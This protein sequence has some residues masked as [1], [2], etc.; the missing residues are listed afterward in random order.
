MTAPAT[1][2]PPPGLRVLV[3]AG[4]AGIGKSIAEGFAAVGARVHISD[5]DADAVSATC[6]DR[7]TGTVADAANEDA[8]RDLFGEARETLGGLDVLVANAG[9]EGPT[10]PISDISAGDWD[11]TLDINLR[12]AYLAA[13]FASEDL[14]ASRG[15]FIGIASV[16][17]RLPFA[18]RT[19]YAASKWGVVGLAKSLA[20]ELGPQGVRANAILPGIVEGPRID[21]VIN[22]RAERLGLSYEEMRE[23][24]L[25]KVALRRMVSPD[26]IAAMCLF[27]NTPGGSNI[28]GQA[29]SVCAGVETL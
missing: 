7:I 17:G 19:P 9:I 20:S 16:A 26:D 1:L 12:G 29:L 4:A 22:A 21:R 15:S 6:S 25:E 23:R 18:Y 28:T 27:L 24:N 10:G 2:T 8:T 14:I 3:T 5:V 13:R 11:K